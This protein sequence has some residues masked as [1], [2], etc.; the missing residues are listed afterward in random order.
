MTVQQ[1][2]RL[3][4]TGADTIRHYVRIGLL[5]PAKGSNGYHQFNDS[6]ARRLSFILQA[7]QLGFT[8]DDIGQIMAQAEH[9][10]SP[11]PTVRQLIEPRLSE[12]RSRLAAMQQLVERMEKAVEQWQHQPDCQPCGT[13]ICHLIEGTDP[14]DMENLHD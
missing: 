8:L 13:H 3:S 14:S 12:A 9:G 4:G 6:D 2:A 5:T 7:R 10:E 1:L 11:C